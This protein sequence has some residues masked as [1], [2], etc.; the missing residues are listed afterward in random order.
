ML[1]KIRYISLITTI[2]LLTTIIMSGCKTVPASQT[3]GASQSKKLVVYAA[4]NESDIV[5]IQKK[6]KTD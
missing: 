1:R 3:P 6:F 5:E 2:V 4:L